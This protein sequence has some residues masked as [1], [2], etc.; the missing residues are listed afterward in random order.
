MKR[1][2]TTTTILV[3][4]CMQTF[5]SGIKFHKGTWA[6]ALA[7]A[8]AQDK[9]IFMD[10]YTSWCGPCKAMAANV[11]PL[12]EVGNYYNN[13]FINVKMDM[14]KGEGRQLSQEYNVRAYPTLLFIDGDGKVVHSSKGGKPAEQFISLGKAALKKYDKSDDYA[15]K[16][17]AGDKSPELLKKYAYALRSAKKDYQKITNEYLLT[18][19]DLTTP[20]NLT[21]LFDL[22][23]TSDSRI[24]GLMIKNKSAILA[25]GIAP[26]DFDQKVIDAAT[27]AVSSAVAFKSENLIKEAKAAVKANV[28]SKAKEFSVEADLVYYQGIG[29][30]A[31]FVKSAGIFAKKYAKNNALKL[32]EIAQITLENCKTNNAFA[33]AEKWAA[34]AIENGGQPT[35]YLTYAQLLAKQ[36]KKTDA[37][38][39]AREG[40]NLAREAKIATAAFDTLIGTLE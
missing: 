7:A 8:K 30:E 3:F 27:E 35:Y 20:E 36:G 14:E 33:Q 28:P 40:R 15:K 11:F 1:L 6:E 29:D 18:Q 13:N 16:Y 39:A 4:V 34:K 9:L 5:A 12:E 26:I 25:Q 21:V 31:K 19:E 37:L 24:F 10:C 32:H 23:S 22:T 2:L 38:K 17:E